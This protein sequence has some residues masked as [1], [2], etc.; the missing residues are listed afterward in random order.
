MAATCDARILIAPHGT[1]A[2]YYLVATH[3]SPNLH[4]SGLPVPTLTDDGA[5][6]VSQSS[7]SLTLPGQRQI[8][9]LFGGQSAEHEVSRVTAAHV[10]AS[11]DP[12]EFR[13][14]PIGI[15]TEGLWL[16]ACDALA[17]QGVSLMAEPRDPGAL[18]V[19]G[20]AVDIGTVLSSA[21]QEQPSAVVL[22]ML[23]G[24]FGEDGTVQGLLEL[25]GVA[26]VGSGVLGSALA[27]DKVMAKQ[28][29]GAVG[30]PQVR[31][32]AVH[33][34]DYR[35]GPPE[36][37]CAST[38]EQLGLPCFVKP[39]NMGSSVGVSRATNL[40]E[41]REAIDAAL[42]Y[43][44]WIVI[45]EAVTARE[46]EVAVI[47]NRSPETSVPGEIRP[48]DEFY[49]YS[50]KYLAGAA[51]LLV[52]APLSASEIAAVQEMAVKVYQSLRCE[53]LARVD[54]FYEDPG[55]GFLC[56]EV[57]TMPGFTPISMFPKLWQHS[58]LSYQN[59]IRRLI[60]LALERAAQ[61]RRFTQ[62]TPTSRGERSTQER[63]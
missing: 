46:I 21:L 52:P 57:N 13:V 50:D 48:A 6:S 55:R 3:T 10:L 34:A 45:E 2:S 30:I 36:R 39:A 58:G 42:L 43:D 28:V 19:V 29:L 15:T 7:S 4:M 62:R 12:A 23:H 53:G 47:G 51:E 61:R 33:E 18:E 44:Q 38:I 26:Y 11:L 54:F 31:Y 40:S 22:P 17:V 14:T 5:M 35:S 63:T 49:S 25:S 41:M 32:T 9:L 1:V 24:P 8:I 60:D 37:F 59:L 27:M 56:S 16:H 20:D